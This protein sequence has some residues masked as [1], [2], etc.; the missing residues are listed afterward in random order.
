MHV[1]CT[2]GRIVLSFGTGVIV[3][4]A[5]PHHQLG[6]PGGEGAWFLGVTYSLVAAADTSA[7][8]FHLV[9]TEA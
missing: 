7:A 1:L 6:L 8:T 4:S 5:G 3:L 9:A 2:A